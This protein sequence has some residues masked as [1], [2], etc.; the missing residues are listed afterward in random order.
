MKGQWCTVLLA[1]ALITKHHQTGD[2]NPNQQPNL[3]TRP[4][5]PD[6]WLFK[7]CGT[8]MRRYTRK[9][10]SGIFMTQRRVDAALSDQGP[11]ISIARS[12]RASELNLTPEQETAIAEAQEK[13]TAVMQ[14]RRLNFGNEVSAVGVKAEISPA[15]RRV[16]AQAHAQ[17]SQRRRPQ[18]HTPAQSRASTQNAQQTSRPRPATT[19]PSQH[20]TEF[21]FVPRVPVHESGLNLGQPRKMLC[22]EKTR[23]RIMEHE[24]LISEYRQWYQGLSPEMKER[25]DAWLAKIVAAHPGNTC[26]V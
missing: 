21:I 25:R 23:H 8:R 17:R 12:L 22:F 5:T 11:C 3:A 16:K 6:I 26:S 2:N 20:S 18:V 10:R 24:R 19:S 14:W 13:L 15:K 1:D 4:P 9:E 7:L